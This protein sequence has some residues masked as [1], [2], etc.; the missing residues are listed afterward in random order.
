MPRHLT[1]RLAELAGLWTA[2][3]KDRS[4]A[5]ALE[6]G[7]IGVALG[8]TLI[9]AIFTVGDDLVALFTGVSTDINSSGN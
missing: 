5:T 7:L 8:V 6:Y 3:C 1:H 4:G 9:A 2:F